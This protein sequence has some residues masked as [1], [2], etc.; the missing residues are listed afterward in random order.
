MLD[1][2]DDRYHLPFSEM[3]RQMSRQGRH[4]VEV[5]SSMEEDGPEI[6][7][8]CVGKDGECALFRTASRIAPVK[9]SSAV[10]EQIGSRSQQA[11]GLIRFFDLHVREPVRAT[12]SRV[13]LHR[14]PQ[15]YRECRNI[16]ELPSESVKTA[17]FARIVTTERTLYGAAKNTK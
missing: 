8:K 10:P 12:N 2:L 5:K 6:V 7:S 15:R 14:S 16:A 13:D 11:I 17:I 3:P 4:D 1:L 9:S